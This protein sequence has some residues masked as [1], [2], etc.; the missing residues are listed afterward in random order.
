MHVSRAEDK[1]GNTIQ[2]QFDG[3]GTNLHSLWNSKLI[4]KEGKTFEKMSIDYYKTT[5]QQIKQWQSD[6]MM[7][8]LFESYEISTKL[9]A[10]V[11]KG[12]KLDDAYYNS[13]IG[14]VNE[15]IE[16]AGI[17]LARVLNQIFANAVYSYPQQGKPVNKSAD[18]API[19]K[20][21]TNL[22]PVI[23]TIPVEEAS[24][25]IGQLVRIT[26]QVYGVKY[27]GSMVFVNMGAAYP[28]QLLTVA[29]KGDV[30]ELANSL[31]KRLITVTGTLID[32]KGKPEIRITDSKQI[33]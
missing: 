4:G 28:N 7:K 10:E 24:K 2:V 27:I 18:L 20:E 33:Q 29:A 26:A 22:K 30:K 6:S 31:D 32:Y 12:N 3:K 5:P 1:G 23:L 14:I 11:D 16:K 15:R 17:R 21:P 19:S 9:Y 25:H 13:H 8:W